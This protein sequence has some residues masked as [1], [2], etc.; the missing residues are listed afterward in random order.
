MTSPR[1]RGCRQLR[2]KA[3]H[4][5]STKAQL[6]VTWHPEPA[7]AVK[8]HLDLGVTGTSS[9]TGAQGLSSQPRSTWHSPP[10]PHQPSAVRSSRRI[11]TVEVSAPG[12]EWLICTGL[13]SHEADKAVAAQEGFLV[14]QQETRQAKMCPYSRHCCIACSMFPCGMGHALLRALLHTGDASS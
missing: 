13:T 7:H 2:A 14:T 9:L 6:E 3:V 1:P 12:S 10:A 11:H 8:G 5:I 4:P